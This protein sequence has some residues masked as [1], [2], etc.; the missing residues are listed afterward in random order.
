MVKSAYLFPH[1]VL[2]IRVSFIPFLN[3]YFGDS[4]N[5]RFHVSLNYLS[6][7]SYEPSFR[8]VI[9]HLNL[10]CVIQGSILALWHSDVI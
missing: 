9:V 3:D 8:Q 4:I 7:C 2:L 6:P 10:D 5:T 1:K